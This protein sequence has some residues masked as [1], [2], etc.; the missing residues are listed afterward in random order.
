MHVKAPTGDHKIADPWE[1]TPHCVLSQ[2]SNQP[3]F[4]VQSTDAEDDRNICILHRKILFPVQLVTDAILKT[5]DNHFAL[6]KA[7]LLMDLYFED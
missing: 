5:D 1:A 7:N 4:K 6:M 3:V 2:L